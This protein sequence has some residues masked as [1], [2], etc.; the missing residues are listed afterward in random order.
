MGLLDKY[1]NLAQPNVGYFSSKPSVL[2]SYREKVSPSEYKDDDP[3]TFSIQDWA[4][5][6]DL[7]SN[8]NDYMVSRLG[9][10]GERKNNESNEDYVKRFISHARYFETNA[11][12]MMGQIDYLRGA[13]EEKRRRF[14]DLHEEYNSL[15]SFGREGG[16]TTGRAIRDYVGAV[17]TDPTWI[18]GFGLGRLGTAILGK[19]GFKAGMKRILPKTAMT[20]SIIGG[21]VSGAVGASGFNLAQQDI[22]RKAYMN[23][24]EPDDEIDLASTA[25]SAIIGAGIGGALGAGAG[26]LTNKAMGL[27][28]NKKAIKE[29]MDEE[30]IKTLDPIE[31]PLT[32][33]ERKYIDAN[34]QTTKS[35][36][37]PKLAKEKL[38]EQLM[39]PNRQTSLSPEPVVDTKVQLELSRRMGKIVEDITQEQKD[40]GAPITLLERKDQKVSD[41]VFDILN[42]IEKI[43][44]DILERA[45]N[46]NNLKVKDF[47]DFLETTDEFA[48][49]ERMTIR[50]AAQVMGYRSALGKMKKTLLEIDPKLSSRIEKM[51]GDKEE[52]TSGMGSFYQFFKRADRERRA[53]MVTQIATTARNVATGVAVV[54]FETAANTL[55]SALYHAGKS[56]QALLK[57]QRSMEGFKAGLREF[58]KDSFGLLEAIARQ[59]RSGE[60]SQFLLENNPRINNILFRALQEV[61]SE[62]QETLSAF[63]RGMNSLN[64]IQDAFFR[65]GFFAFDI[66]RKL[67]RASDGKQSLSTIYEQGKSVPVSVLK[68]SMEYALK[69]TF[70]LMPRSGPAHHFVKFVEAFPMVPVIGTGEFPFARF[71]ANAMSFQLKY[72][73]ANAAYGMFQGAFRGAMTGLGKDVSSKQ[74]AEVRDRISKG[75]VGTAA[76]MAAINIRSK[77]QDTEWY[78]ITTSDG[79]KIDTRPFFPAA[80]YMIVA[81]MIVKYNNGELDKLKGKDFIDGFTGAQFRAGSASY[82]VDKFYEVIGTEGGLESIGTERLGEIIGGYLGEVTAGFVTPLRVV[83]DVVAA[84]DEEEAIVRDSNAIEGIGTKERAVNAFIAKIQKN[85]PILSQQ[86]PE[87]ES[88]TR[89]DT[90]RTQSPLFGQILGLRFQERANPAEK[91]LVR[92]G[93]KYFE[94]LPSL[95]DK[96]ADLYT[97]R[98]LGPLVETFIGKLIESP[99]YA[100]MSEAQ[101]KNAVKLELQRLRVIAKRIGYSKSLQDTTGAFTPFDRGKWINLPRGLRKL[102][103]EY[104]KTHNKGRTIEE[105]GAYR[106]GIIIGRNLGKLG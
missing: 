44:T 10:S 11:I 96:K 42:N 3:D 28:K 57:G 90:V 19:L 21:S 82:T 105:D 32:D 60:F 95:G 30:E 39:P 98:E 83:K 16:D 62:K 9:E 69:N 81:D 77:N 50:E 85:I 88:P 2:D 6:R 106:V 75:M 5:D 104:Y 64:I 24:K 79:R 99:R 55:D 51:F 61:G 103:N 84:F 41:V 91:E 12:G 73:P 65:R 4:N 101:K 20:K 54:T 80:P 1:R 34:K 67:R 48:Q 27:G 94:I 26:A 22:Q 72:N 25:F 70:A 49:M 40:A 18:L 36:F 102:A 23:D 38:D 100:E 89:E 63:S 76:L 97:K 29:A 68:G 93:Y 47:L 66:D 87:F 8:L 86:L 37:D 15:P 92:L 35:E 59:S 52:V 13:D 74:W 33:A 46:K 58:S 7:M 56:A 17:A 71:M 43:D 53:L 31:G 45:L 14:G 78:N